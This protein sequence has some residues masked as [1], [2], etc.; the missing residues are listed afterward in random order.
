MRKKKLRRLQ[1]KDWR[2]KRDELQL[3]SVFK[4]TNDNYRG[5]YVNEYGIKFIHWFSNPEKESF[6]FIEKIRN[7]LSENEFNFLLEEFCP[8]K[9]HKI[10]KYYELQKEE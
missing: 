5:T 9:K 6:D 8:K 7:E 1:G 10:L 2:D 3:I 4:S